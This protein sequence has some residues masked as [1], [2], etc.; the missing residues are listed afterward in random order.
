M[1]VAEKVAARLGDVEV[2]QAI[3]DWV[4][5]KGIVA[6]TYVLRLAACHPRGERFVLTCPFALPSRP[7]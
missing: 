3:L 1:P 6:V 5:T 4:K 2:G 7:V